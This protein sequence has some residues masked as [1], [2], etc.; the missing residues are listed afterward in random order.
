MKD[1]EIIELYLTRSNKAI[2]FTK[3]KYEKLCKKI[4][5]NMLNN[6]QDA[7]ECFN[8]ALMT[9]WETIPPNR[10]ESLKAYLCKT[11]KNI[12]LKKIEYNSAKKRC[13]EYTKSL[14][15]LKDCLSTNTLIEDMIE[16]EELN[17]AINKF[18]YSLPYQ[19]RI[20]FVRRYYFLHSVK[21]IAADYNISE[22]NASAK[23]ARIRKQLKEFLT[24][25]GYLNE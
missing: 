25:E 3:E 9:L 13:S 23:L 19:K 18:L 1:E 22:K 10:P 12:S 20:M 24:K 21:E 7:E 2:E 15:E 6:I 17:N 16:A 8:D 14:D 4:S 5:M 11:V